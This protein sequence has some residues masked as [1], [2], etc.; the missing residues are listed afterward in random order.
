LL[1]GNQFRDFEEEWER[2]SQDNGFLM[3]KIL[4]LSNT[5]EHVFVRHPTTIDLIQTTTLR[6]S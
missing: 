1:F 3:L 2:D 6:V 5:I 4:V